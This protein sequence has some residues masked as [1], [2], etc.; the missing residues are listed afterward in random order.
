MSDA[1][2]GVT[3]LRD[4]RKQA[5][6]V[7]ARYEKAGHG[8][9]LE[10]L[11]KALGEKLTETEEKIH[12]YRSKSSQDVL[13]FRPG[14]DGQLVGLKSTVESADARPTDASVERFNELRAELDGYLAELKAIFDTDLVEFN[15]KVA[16]LDQP[17]VFPSK[18]IPE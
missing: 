9:G 1:H 16:E 14:I 15:V 12:Q 5:K 7:A 4:V 10:D 2:R 17:A 3:Q 11:A 6:D 18:G 13:N 8:E